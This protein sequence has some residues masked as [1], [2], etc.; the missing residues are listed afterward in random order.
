MAEKK[1]K[2]PISTFLDK[3]QDVTARE[4]AARPTHR[5]LE[6]G[7]LRTAGEINRGIK[8]ARILPGIRRERDTLLSDLQLMNRGLTAPPKRKKKKPGL[9]SRIAKPYRDYY[10][11]KKDTGQATAAQPP[12]PTP[13]PKGVVERTVERGRQTMKEKRR[14]KLRMQGFTEREIKEME[15]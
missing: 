11:G 12:R 4:R 7:T 1:K 9:L 3:A 13:Q 15:P 6:F 2:K 10:G 14:E 8:N 5:G